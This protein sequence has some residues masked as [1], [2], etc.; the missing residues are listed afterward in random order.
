M[1][2]IFSTCPKGMLHVTALGSPAHPLPPVPSRHL[3]S[4]FASHL[5]HNHCFF[6][7]NKGQKV[8]AK[9]SCLHG[10][11]W[12]AGQALAVSASYGQNE[13]LGTWDGAGLSPRPGKPR[14]VPY[15]EGCHRL[16]CCEMGERSCW[17]SKKAWELHL[18]KKKKVPIT[19]L[20]IRGRNTTDLVGTGSPC[21]LQ[22]PGSKVANLSP[23]LQNTQK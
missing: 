1:S 12:K 6:Q 13:R 22:M 10:A 4:H 3:N 17:A 11:L 18:L 2:H 5:F 19:L 15:S 9:Q 16:R 14:F 23:C 20:S 21:C 8:L 7:K